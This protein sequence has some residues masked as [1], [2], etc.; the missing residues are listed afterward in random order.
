MSLMDHWPNQSDW[1]DHLQK[2]F[3]SEAARS[4]SNFVDQQRQDET[5]FP[6]ADSVFNAFRLTS[7]SNTKVVILG[8]DPYHG[9]GQAHGLSFSVGKSAERFPP[10]LRNIFKELASDLGCP[11]PQT[12]NLEPWARQGVLLLN[13]VLTVRSGE[14][15]AHK[16]R[17]WES[18]TDA[19]I[20]SLNSHSAKIVF[21]L[22]GKSAEKKAFLIADR[23]IQL[24][25]P[26]PSPLSAHRGFFGSRPFSNANE[27]LA[28]QGL[29]TIDWLL[30]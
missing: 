17:G 13:T 16:N 15:H 24:V 26:H 2:W 7:W 19:V 23:H 30:E 1:S 22:W 5:V 25:A 8:Q 6:P 28:R 18:F 27:M 4:L 20:E 29:D 11:I 12:S 9:P 10:S 21:L 14:A 3:D